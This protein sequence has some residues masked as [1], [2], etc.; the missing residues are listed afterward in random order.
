MTVGQADPPDDASLTRGREFR[1]RVVGKA[2]HRTSVDED[3][4]DLITKYAF[5][6]VWCR[7]GLAFDTRR[8]LTLAMTIAGGH[9]EEFKLHLRFALANGVDRAAVKEVMLQ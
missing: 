9:Y 4:L 1:T 2:K 7:P 6:D 8:M 3:L 5:G